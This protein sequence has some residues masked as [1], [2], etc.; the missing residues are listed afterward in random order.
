MTKGVALNLR[1]CEQQL[2]S[3]IKHTLWL[4]PTELSQVM[5]MLLVREHTLRT[6][7]VHSLARDLTPTSPLHENCSHCHETHYNC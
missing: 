6:A 5:L 3:L 2:R 1:A 4:P 7:S